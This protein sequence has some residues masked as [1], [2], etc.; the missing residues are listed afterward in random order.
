MLNSLFTQLG[1]LGVKHQLRTSAGGATRNISSDEQTLL[2]ALL[3]A[4]LPV[5]NR[6]YN[7]IDDEGTFRGVLDFAWD[8]IEG[9]PVRVAIELDGWYWHGG[10]DVAKEIASWFPADPK[11]TKAVDEEER[12]RGARDAGKR[13]VMVER[14][15]SL[16][17]VHDTEVRGG[18]S[19]EIAEGIRALISRRYLES[20]NET[21]PAV[22]SSA[23]A[24]D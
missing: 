19:Q 23:Q 22:M 2:D 6:N 13:R 20:G 11:I 18:K 10:A 5:P 14:G 21:V 8:E 9:I 17:T 16:V 4:G 1:V 15:W 7:V 12:A 24:G 3:R